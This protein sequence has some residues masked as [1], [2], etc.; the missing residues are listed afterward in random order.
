MRGIGVMRGN[1]GI[2]SEFI[3]FGCRGQISFFYKWMR[4]KSGS[5][6]Y[7]P[8]SF[9]RWKL[10]ALVRR[11]RLLNVLVSCNMMKQESFLPAGLILTR[12]DSRVCGNLATMKCKIPAPVNPWI[13]DFVKIENGEKR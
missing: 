8:N 10:E 1:R 13:L 2:T 4:A 3:T 5:F 6:L 11:W 9:Y 7:F 12:N